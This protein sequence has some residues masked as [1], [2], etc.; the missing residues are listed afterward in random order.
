MARRITPSCRLCRRENEKLFLKGTR[1]TSAK[2]TFI[3][4]DFAPGQ[5]GQKRKRGKFS[6][7]ATQ[8]REKQKAKRY[9][10]VLEKQFKNYFRKAEQ[11]KGT[12][13][14]VLFQFL[15]RRLDNLV[16]RANFAASRPKARQ[17][18]R[19][20]FVKV[21]GRKVDIP[22]Y[23]VKAGDEIKLTGSDNQK[24]VI[25]E[26][27]KILSDRMIPEWLEVSSEN[28]SVKVKRLPAKADIGMVFQENLIV[29]LYSK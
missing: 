6:D 25:M 28:L 18:V 12:T 1:C 11:S 19:H 17:I 4:R 15:E 16:F 7:Y 10:G 14:E 24:K 20:R 3:K 2:C 8:L 9:Y 22:S 23:V 26:T 27:A 5:H 29:E 13:G 21:N